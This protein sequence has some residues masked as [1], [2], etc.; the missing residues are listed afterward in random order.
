MTPTS[1]LPNGFSDDFSRAPEASE[2]QRW[3]IYGGYHPAKWSRHPST[4]ALIW[5]W[6]EG[7]DEPQLT[8]Y[9]DIHPAMN[10]VGLW[11]HP[12]VDGH[13]R[14]P[15]PT[16]GGAVLKELAEGK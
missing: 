16:P 1:T 10:A 12:A 6:R 3:P 2:W 15:I 7:W 8:A 11:W 4:S 5:L 14:P 13:G 9:R